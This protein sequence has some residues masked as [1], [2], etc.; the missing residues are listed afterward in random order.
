MLFFDL[1][2]NPLIYCR[3]THLSHLMSIQLPRPNF[4]F[5]IFH[6]FSAVIYYS[7]PNV[8]LLALLPVHVGHF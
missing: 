7:V 5:K 4:H 6:T 8:I 1:P 3:P 2:A